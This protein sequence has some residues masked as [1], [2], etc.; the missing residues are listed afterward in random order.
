[1]LVAT[2]FGF[3]RF[4]RL[5][6]L[7]SYD[8]CRMSV[9]TTYVSLGFRVA[10]LWCPKV[11]FGVGCNSLGFPVAWESTPTT[12]ICFGAL[13][14]SF[15]TPMLFVSVR[16]WFEQTQPTPH[17]LVGCSSRL[18]GGKTPVYIYAL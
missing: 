8:C 14:N 6:Q 4:G 7:F 15:P 17:G 5:G 10:D 12:D 11:V 3:F 18:L 9:A 2:T 1:M 13:M 16:C